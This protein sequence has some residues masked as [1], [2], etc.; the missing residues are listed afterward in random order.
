M[1]LDALHDRS[2][3]PAWMHLDARYRRVIAGVARRQGLTESDA[4]E[5]AQETLVEFSKAY[6]A[7]QYDRS[8]G[9]LSSWILGMAR[10]FILRSVRDRARYAHARDTV[11]AQLPDAR[12]LQQ[13]WEDERDRLLLDQAMGYLRDDSALDD[14]TL[15]AFELVALRGVPVATVAQQ[16][17]MTPEQIYVAKSRVTRKLRLLVQELTSAFEEDL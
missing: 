9:R 2:N 17:L 11:I 16:C 3:E 13:H 6:R 5:V 15:Q 1:L 7:G 8:K 14:R 4:D 10:N 12:S